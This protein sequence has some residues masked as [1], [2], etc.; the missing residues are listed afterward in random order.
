MNCFQFCIFAVWNTTRR[1]TPTPLHRLWI[2]FNFVS[3]QCE[4][5]L[6]LVLYI[7][8]GCCELLSILYLCSVK[9]N[10][11][12]RYQR[13]KVVVNCFQ[14][15]IFAVWNTTLGKQVVKKSCCELLSILYLCSVK[16]NGTAFLIGAPMLWIAFNF[17]SLQCE[18]QRISRH[19]IT[20]ISCELL[21][22][23]YLCSVK[24]NFLTTCLKSFLVVNCFQFCI[25]A[26]W[27]TTLFS[28]IPD[29][30]ELWIA[31]NF[32]SLQCETQLF[33]F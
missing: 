9:H 32:V 18:T 29:K 30:I 24:H 7:Y 15:C 19:F 11:V 26:V 22:I 21:S 33:L 13:R 25:F 8:Y 27:N 3:L 31:F 14:F 12:Y 6:R 2:A 1:R 28:A 16:H 17:V 10:Q 4:T 20:C 23:L 5:Q